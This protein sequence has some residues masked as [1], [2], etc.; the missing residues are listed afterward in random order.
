[1]SSKKKE[2]TT[3]NNSQTNA[4][5]E[6]TKDIYP[7][8]ADKVMAAL[9]TLPGKYYEGDFLAQP[10]Q[11]D[12]DQTANAWTRAWQSGNNGGMGIENLASDVIQ[13]KGATF[14]PNAQLF[15]GGLDFSSLIPGAGGM[16]QAEILDLPDFMSYKPT[17]TTYMPSAW[18]G[19][20][21]GEARLNAAMDVGAQKVMRQLTDQ[22]LPGIK[23]SALASGAY[24]GDRAMLIEP[25]KAIADAAGRANE[26]TQGLAYEGYQAEQDRS[27]QAWQALEGLRQ[28]AT[29]SGNQDAID[30]F[31]VL[32]NA[33]LSGYGTQQGAII[34]A[35]ALASDNLFRGSD[36]NIKAILEQARLQNDAYGLATD[37]GLAAHGSTLDN[38]KTA[39]ELYAL[40]PEVFGS[41]A[42]AA[43]EAMNT[44]MFGE[45][46]AIDNRLA[47][48]T[49]DLQYPFQGLDMVTALLSQLS[50]NYGTQTGEGQQTTVTKTGG[51]GEIMKGILG[52]AGIA[53]SAFAPI[54]GAAAAAGS[55]AKANPFTRDFSKLNWGS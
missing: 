22:V 16:P 21:D 10:D 36:M 23:S 19:G 45:Q 13:N 18:G 31:S 25:G 49:Y 54:G 34:D 35:A 15:S 52:A 20:T 51:A 6:W 29:A 26:V 37:R 17:L 11:T 27:L 28:A 46:Q 3:Y 39:A 8:V 40:A 48:D 50:G 53:A 30:L 43:G 12:L 4:P 42:G 1:M 14:D 47:R 38:A 5:P 33:M 7:L 24:T 44:K 9:G 55:V 2:T 41:A 32:S